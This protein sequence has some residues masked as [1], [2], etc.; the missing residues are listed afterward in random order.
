MM[1]LPL[2][3]A[4]SVQDAPDTMPPPVKADSTNILYAPSRSLRSA[5]AAVA[6]V[7]AAPVTV[8]LQCTVE[9]DSGAPTSCVPLENGAKPVTSRAELK[10][11]ETAWESGAAAAAPAVTVALQRVRFTRV[12]PTAAVGTPGTP[13]QMIFA[14]TVGAGD[15]VRLGAPT[16]V[17]ASSDMEMDERPDGAIL[18][19]YY[20]AQA[21]RAGIQARIKASC[22]VMPDR[23][24]FC[25]DAE[26]VNP[27][28]AITPD[29]AAEFRNATY[30]VFDAVRLAPLSKTGDPV[31]GRDV[32]MRISFVLP[33]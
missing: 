6:G 24:L 18:T 5:S 14:E 29:I 19:A 31:V 13:V 33:N 32:D 15:V 10:R 4:L 3:L 8:R 27:D 26:L 16:G 11:R 2:L 9:T 20:P 1:I 28:A 25:H 30:Q 22:R 23:K 17:I 21:L 7:P 12:R